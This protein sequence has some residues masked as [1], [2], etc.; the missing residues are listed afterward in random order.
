MLLCVIL[1]ALNEEATIGKVIAQIRETRLPAAITD[2]AVVVVDDGS[3]DRT[4]EIA[5]GL[6]AMVVRHAANRGVGR[7][8][9]SGLE[10]SL[11]LG[12]DVIVNID[13]DGQFNPA[14]IPL[15]IAPVIQGRAGFVTASRFKDSALEPEMPRVKRWGNRAMSRLVSFIVGR[16]F[17][18]VS[19]GF[20]AYSRETA[21]RLNL[22]GE[23]TY[24]QETFIFL[25]ARGL[26]IEEIPIRVRGVREIGE[27][28]VARNLWTYGRR[29]SAIMF[30]AYRD[31]WPMRFFGILGVLAL[32]PGLSCL[33]FLGLHW[34]RTGRF[35]PHIW[36]GFTG[37][38]FVFL[39]LACFLT[40]LLGS[41][42]KRIRLNQEEMLYYLK[43][44]HY[45]SLK[46][47]AQDGG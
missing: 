2:C 19:C 6:G 1:P 38:S 30:H 46:K 18:D 24:T 25:C 17:H 4:A 40:G 37:G 35:S 27:S 9:Q 42:L 20:R 39:A 10:K 7:A 8:F 29:S 15:L 47:G 34:L 43:S 36:A 41:M 44:R 33:S 3:A 16:R 26:Q 5:A 14:D 45:Q 22:W 13:A 32:L 23:F 12:A 31:F 28:R 21:L 11:E